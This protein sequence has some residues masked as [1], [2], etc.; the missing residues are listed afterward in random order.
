MRESPLL[1]ATPRAEAH[2]A[3]RVSRRSIGTAIR[4]GRRY[5]QVRLTGAKARVRHSASLLD[6]ARCDS[7]GNVRRLGEMMAEQKETIGLAVGAREPGTNRGTTRGI[8]NPAS[9]PTLAE[10]RRS[11]GKRLPLG[12]TQ[13]W[14][15]RREAG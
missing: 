8:E 9:P 7:L 10:H 15:W 3:S 6:R 2:A 1:V 12:T 11:N 5:R 14:G 4:G 13:R